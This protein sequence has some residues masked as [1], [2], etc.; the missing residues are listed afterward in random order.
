MASQQDEEVTGAVDV[1]AGTP[2]PWSV[3]V[4]VDISG[5]GSGDGG[6]GGGGDGGVVEAVKGKVASK[7]RGKVHVHLMEGADRV[8]SYVID[9]APSGRI[10]AAFLGEGGGGEGGGGGGS[11][12][13]SAM[14]QLK[15]VFRVDQEGVPSVLSARCASVALKKGLREGGGGGGGQRKMRER[16]DR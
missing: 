3:D 9:L 15:F 2:I 8:A 12:G 7:H 4:P 10:S 1:P 11:G 5:S 6:H 13:G 14:P 16:K